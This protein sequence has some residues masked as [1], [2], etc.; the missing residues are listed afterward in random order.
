MRL[1]R[2]ERPRFPIDPR[3]ARI[4][5]YLDGL[6]S[7]YIPAFDDNWARDKS[8]GAGHTNARTTTGT[9]FD[10][11]GLMKT[12]EINAQRFEHD[13][14][15]GRSLGV[16]VEDSA[17]CINKSSQDL[18]TAGAPDNAN[19]V[20]EWAFTV[21]GAVTNDATAD[22]GPDG[23][24]TANAFQTGLGQTNRFN[25]TTSA[26]P[27]GTQDY[28]ASI[29][30][31]RQPG[32]TNERSLTLQLR[33]QGGGGTDL[34]KGLNIILNSNA[35]LLSSN[36]TRY[37]IKLCASSW[38]RKWLSFADDGSGGDGRLARLFI[39]SDCVT[40]GSG[41][42]SRH[43]LLWGAN[44][45]FGK[46]PT[47]HIYSTASSTTRA[48]DENSK[49]ITWN[50]A[51][52]SFLFQFRA[53]IAIALD[54]RTLACF[55]D[56]TAD[57]QIL[58]QSTNGLLSAIVRVSGIQVASMPLGSLKEFVDYSVA[59]RFRGGIVS[60]KLSGNGL[61]YATASAL[62]TPTTVRIGHDTSF[63]NYWN[64]AVGRMAH[65]SKWLPDGH[66][67]GLAP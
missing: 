55:D 59:L 23:T 6:G 54:T 60:G 64:G 67:Y 17:T 46:Y 34:L 1:F 21:G 45:A 37:G 26:K 57:N 56:G 48:R 36:P 11:D 42:A 52:N 58:L 43:S 13:P 63:A 16:L 28:V 65:I 14:I 25:N 61:M 32:T 2:V 51:E 7:E 29:F 39:S 41:G 12:A 38:V 47:S 62:P 66:V 31:K 20:T 40:S 35:I 4:S 18:R 19:P 22:T 30:V 24:Q 15:T 44:L 3:I 27:T 50:S 10:S 33:Y 49:S 53:P 9:W 5:E 8:L